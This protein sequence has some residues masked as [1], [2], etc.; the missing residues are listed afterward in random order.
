MDMQMR[1]DLVRWRLEGQPVARVSVSGARGSTPRAAG[2][3]MLLTASEQSGTIGGGDLEWNAIHQA[4]ALLRTG[5]A[6]Q[7]VRISLG[8]NSGQCCGGEV[9]LTLDLPDADELEDVLARLEQA[10]RTQPLLLL[11]GAGHVGRALAHV[12]APLPLR[13]AWCDSRPHEFG[14][15]IPPGVT[16]HDDGDWE[17]LVATAPPGSGALVLTQS[18]ALDSLIVASILERGDFRYVGLIGSATKR[19][20]FEAGFRQIG[21]PDA[22][23]AT[24]VCPIGDRGVRDKRPAVIAALVAAEIVT[25]FLH[26]AQDEGTG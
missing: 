25:R 26:P 5:G 20:R 22:R 14:P 23:I 3:F 9:T 13:L 19:R 8:G 2:T 21:L 10:R 11:F 15:T 1:A 16:V 7:E 17:G 24:M 12:L 18:H 4:R 6:R